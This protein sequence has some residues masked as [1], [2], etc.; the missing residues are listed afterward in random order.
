[1]TVAADLIRFP[2]VRAALEPPFPGDAAEYAEQ[3]IRLPSVSVS[4][5]GHFSFR[6]A[7]HSREW[8]EAMSEPGQVTMSTGT[9]VAKTTVVL[10]RLAFG[11]AGRPAPALYVGPRGEDVQEIVTRRFAPICRSSPDLERRMPRARRDWTRKEVAFGNGA[12]V[13]TGTGWSV[14]SVTGKPIAVVIGDEFDLW[15]NPRNHL[16]LMKQRLQ[17]WKDQG[18]CVL[19]ANPF[20]A[21]GAGGIWDQFLLGDQRHYFVPCPHCGEE[22]KLE[23]SQ[24]R[25]RVDDQNQV[26][27]VTY[28]CAHCHESIAD[29]AKQGMM[30]AG[31]WQA[32]R[33]APGH[34]SYTM[35][36]LY[37][38]DVTWSQYAQALHEA[39]LDWE[40]HGQMFC[41]LWRGAPYEAPKAETL[42]AG[43]PRTRVQ[44]RRRG[45]VPREAQMLVAGVDTQVDYMVWSVR[46]VGF[47]ME[48][49]GVDYGKV[50]KWEELTE[51][52]FRRRWEC[53]DQPPPIAR[54]CIDMSDG[55]RTDEVYAWALDHGAVVVPARG[56]STCPVPTRMH[57]VET[58]KLQLGRGRVYVEWSHEWFFGAMHAG[59]RKLPGQRGAWWV[60]EDAEEEYFRQLLNRVREQE[61]GRWLWKKKGAD[62]YADAEAMALVAAE[63]AGARMLVRGGAAAADAPP[64]AATNAEAA[65]PAPR[66]MSEA[67][68]M[69]RPAPQPERQSWIRGG[70]SRMLD[71][72]RR[73]R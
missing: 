1:M 56:S 46:A 52:M 35:S 36:T 73:R 60:P 69:V 57:R 12:V 2:S 40:A 31:R 67:D 13:H 28:E 54:V 66:R 61:K 15:R 16:K 32:T 34:R 19:A 50:F 7:P 47:D 27:D 5:S 55:N 41:A 22:Q 38:L 44:P 8:L 21:P 10:I 49:W 29:D 4:K 48:T 43:D 51:V 59:M 53:Y 20:L 58:S 6:Y 25:Y 33:L 11:V 37:S 23:E 18:L 9:Q 24:L 64:A 62:H 26:R 45:T 14:A 30:I 68:R 65:P 72:M 63:I 3:H 70:R 17:T 42:K 71:Q 39:S